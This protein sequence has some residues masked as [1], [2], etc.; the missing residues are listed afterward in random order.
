MSW[1][2]SLHLKSKV[3]SLLIESCALQLVSS[4]S[5]FSSK[6][7]K[8]LFKKPVRSINIWLL[9]YLSNLINLFKLIPKG[10]TSSEECSPW[11]AMTKLSWISFWNQLWTFFL[12]SSKTNQKNQKERNTCT[13]LFNPSKPSRTALSPKKKFILL[14]NFS[15]NTGPSSSKSLD[16]LR[17]W[18]TMKILM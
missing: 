15:E 8:K 11:S 7:P 5:L 9:T 3:T 17:K 13:H 2:D 12:S 6:Q 1:E 14:S 18:K 4:M 16:H 10:H